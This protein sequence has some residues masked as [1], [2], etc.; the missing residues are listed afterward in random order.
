L[1]K[2]ASQ[3]NRG[4]SGHLIVFEPSG[5]SCRAAQ[6]TTLRDI[7]IAQKIDLRAECAGKGQCGQCVVRVR[8][9]GHLTPPTENELRVLG[10]EKLSTG[11]RLACQAGVKGR[12][13][14]WSAAPQARDIATAGKQRL[15]ETFKTEP[16]VSRLFL[17]GR[18]ASG[19]DDDTPPDFAEVLVLNAAEAYGYKLR[20]D[21]PEALRMLGRCQSS[22]YDLTLV[23]H[24]LKGVTAVWKGRSPRSLG[25]AM[26]IGTSTLAVYLC[27]FATG[28]VAAAGA[29]PN[30][31][32]RFG[33][34]VISRIAFAVEKDSGL[35]DLHGLVVAEIN[36][37]ISMCL[38]DA[39]AAHQ[40]IDELSVA[41][42]PTM[43]QI[44]MN[45]HPR[46]LGTAPYLPVS[47]ASKNL[48]AMDLGLNLDS[49]ANAYVLPVMSGFVGGDTMGVVLSERPHES[50]AVS[51]IVDIGTN[52]ELV[53]GNRHGLWATSCATGPAF[54]GGHISCGMPAAAGA[55][56][57][58]KIDPQS[59]RTACEVLGR[60]QNTTAQ[61]ICGSGIVD[62]AAEMLRAGLLLPSGR[63]K[64]GMPGVVAD[65][66][67]I[68][69][70]FVLIPSPAGSK[71]REIA[72]TLKDIRQ[73]QLAKAALFAG[74]QLL[75]SRAGITRFD[76][77]ILTGAFGARFNWKNAVRIGMLPPIAAQVEVKV[78]ENA[79]GRGAVMA[80]LDGGLRSRADELARKV[81]V[82]NL[83]E[84][85]DFTAVFTSATL[86][87]DTARQSEQ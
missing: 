85:P 84:D 33:E 61:G 4:P 83:A 60:E 73:I 28:A 51:L 39:K 56:H 41:G 16:M 64:E 34:D 50:E 32:R 15:G 53:L 45:V 46:G 44:F 11:F 71:N 66:N 55:V 1:S 67:G 59:G 31:Q 68:G 19:S 13:T 6:G 47:R 87:P 48:R 27:D 24:R 21:D 29:A 76:R 5:I 7:A 69:R 40:D 9:A 86:F 58:V 42:N 20:F 63:L 35:A 70:K 22:A 77:L 54:E 18:T 30:P 72:F 82:L 80:L 3:K 10:A 36:G 79:A 23:N 49:A 8:P 26:D 78:V 12:L 81:K 2:P 74:I 62:A 43:Q 57:R 37:L 38:N 75:M 17:S 52:G 25:I 14:V 65:E